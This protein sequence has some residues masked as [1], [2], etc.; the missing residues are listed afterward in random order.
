MKKFC[1]RGSRKVKRA[2]FAGRVG[3]TYISEYR[4]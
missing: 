2:V 1:A 4:A 3:A